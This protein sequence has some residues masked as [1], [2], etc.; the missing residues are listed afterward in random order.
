MRTTYQYGDVDT[1]T[2]RFGLLKKSTTNILSQKT[3][4]V[5]P[6]ATFQT[7][8]WQMTLP[9]V[10]KLLVSPVPIDNVVITKEIEKEELP[11]ALENK[12]LTLL[13]FIDV[14][15]LSSGRQTS[16]QSSYSL[17]DLKE[18]SKQLGVFKTA[19][20]KPYL[21]EQIKLQLDNVLKGE[22]NLIHDIKKLNE[23]EIRNIKT[24]EKLFEKHFVSPKTSTDVIKKITKTLK[25]YSTSTELNRQV[26]QTIENEWQPVKTKK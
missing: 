4:A 19:K 18:L 2:T 17:E 14:D 8:Q 23:D 10:P 21:I 11:A 1:L 9:L 16:K 22:P 6:K 13:N 5:N 25:K 3:Q 20:P 12:T 24:I 15:K 26:I 7:P